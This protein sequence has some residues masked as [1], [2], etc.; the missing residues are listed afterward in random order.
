MNDFIKEQQELARKTLFGDSIYCGDRHCEEEEPCG[1][2]V[3]SELDTLI[4]QIITNTGKELMRLAEG[5]MKPKSYWCWPWYRDDEIAHNAAVDTIKK[6][7][8]SVTR[9]E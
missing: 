5:E 9:V 8:T 7:I 1:H 6:H 4:Q 2:A 3:R